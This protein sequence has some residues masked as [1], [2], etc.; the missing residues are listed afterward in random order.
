M[1]R[2]QG[3]PPIDTREFE[4][5]VRRAEA[6]FAADAHPEV[7]QPLALSRELRGTA[8]AVR[9]HLGADSATRSCRAPLR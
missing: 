2:G 4:D 7:A 3:R 6:R 1:N 8:A 9:A 5:Y